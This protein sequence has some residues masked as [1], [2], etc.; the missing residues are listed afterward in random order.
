LNGWL[1]LAG[2]AGV[3]WLAG[4]IALFAALRFLKW[5]IPFVFER[6]DVSHKHLGQRIQ[7]LEVELDCYREVAMMLISAVASIEPGHPS[8]VRAARLLRDRA[9]RTTLELDELYERLA[10]MER[11]SQGREGHGKND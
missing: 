4:A 1:I 2:Q 8:L 11:V 7:H 10:Q 9:P 5:L 6:M 3:R